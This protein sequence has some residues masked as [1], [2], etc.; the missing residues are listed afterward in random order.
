MFFFFCNF[1]FSKDVFFLK[2]FVFFWERKVFSFFQTGLS[3]VCFLF[4]RFFLK[5]KGVFN[6]KEKQVLFSFSNLFFE[7]C[8]FVQG[9]LCLFGL[10]CFFVFFLQVFFSCI[11]FCK[12]FRV[13]S[14]FWFCVVVFCSVF[15]CFFARV[16]FF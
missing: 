13:S 4:P 12:A 16:C 2:V 5:K 3:G 6:S 8:F 9:V 14:C 10:L 15:F 11:F 1:F 7:W